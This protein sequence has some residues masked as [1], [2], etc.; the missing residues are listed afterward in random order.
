LL[1]AAA[2]GEQQTSLLAAQVVQVAAV[3][4]QEALELLLALQ[5]QDHSQ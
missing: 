2:V 1:L 4:A 5:F 3:A